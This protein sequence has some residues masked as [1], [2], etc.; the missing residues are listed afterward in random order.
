MVTGD[1]LGAGV[2]GVAQGMVLPLELT[3]GT[4]LPLR[5]SNKNLNLLP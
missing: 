1:L 3:K 4:D 2:Q 5:V